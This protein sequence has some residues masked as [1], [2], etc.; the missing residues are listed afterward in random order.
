MV[1]D[2]DFSKP[3]LDKLKRA[4]DQ[5][6]GITVESERILSAL[7]LEA[8]NYI[9]P[10]RLSYEVKIEKC[11][12]GKGFSGLSLLVGECVHNMRS[13]LDNLVYALARLQEDPPS[14]PRK[15][16]FPVYTEKSSFEGRAKP[17]LAKL[18]S[19][20]AL[21]IIEA[22]Q[23]FQRDSEPGGS[24][25]N[26]LLYAISEINNSDKHRLPI[27]ALVNIPELNHV[28]VMDFGSA[29]L[30]ALNVPP[31][32]SMFS[33]AAKVGTVLMSGRFKTPVVSMSGNFLLKVELII[34]INGRAVGL[35]D[36]ISKSHFYVSN[37]VSLFLPQF[38]SPTS[39]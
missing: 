1:G 6:H 28:A 16:S 35:L 31:D 2:H 29:E 32:Y 25:E 19:G 17:A 10:D 3:C 18:L 38:K 8:K 23:P 12:D 21:R 5:L 20:D 30:A 33:G 4:H 13:S 36:L 34:D 7:T 11:G 22:L 27:S 24:G 39:I 9:S 37:V 26:D 14:N 15:L